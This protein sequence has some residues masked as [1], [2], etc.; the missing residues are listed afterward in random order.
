MKLTTLILG[1]AVAFW[2]LQASAQT[3]SS[4]GKD[5]GRVSVRA[6]I[7]AQGSPDSPV[8][9]QLDFAGLPAAGASITYTTEG[10]LTLTSAASKRLTPDSKGRS[11]DT[12]VVRAAAAGV[13]FLNVF[14]SADGVTQAVSIP[15]TVGT[16]ILKPRAASAV[17]TPTGGRT[18]DMPAQQTI[19]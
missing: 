14:A 1:C 9:V 6:A 16:A 8:K 13:Y 11:H 17:T 15:V 19:R 3:G 12:V 7:P 4:T 2:G 5:Y 18:I 10:G